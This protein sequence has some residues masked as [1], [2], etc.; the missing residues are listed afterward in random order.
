MDLTSLIYGGL[1]ILQIISMNMLFSDYAR[2]YNHRFEEDR[3]QIA[4]NYAVDA[5]TKEMQDDSANL[6]QDYETM[7]KLNV[8]PIVAYDTFTTIIAKNYNVPVNSTSQQEIMLD[9]CPVFMVASY[10]GY[11]LMDKVKINDAGVDNMVFGPKMP[12]TQKYTETDGTSSIYSYNLGLTSAIKIDS[13]GGVY[14]TEN[15]PLTRNQQSSLINSTISDVINDNLVVL[16]NKDPRGEVYIPSNM[17]TVNSTNPIQH[18]T[19]FAYIDNFNLSGYGMDLQS[20]GIGGAEIRQKKV[21]VGFTIEVDGKL[22][23][24]Y[25]YSDKVPNGVNKVETF[26]SQED[27]AKEGYYFYIN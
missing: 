2:D 11:Y 10:D 20:F 17:T 26:D 23:K 21:V 9:Y 27:A 8:D 12:Y 3:L 16:A 13:G 7:A 15:P 4:V 19:V 6:A 22:Q 1:L 14:K 5:A 18:T 24:Y 25:A